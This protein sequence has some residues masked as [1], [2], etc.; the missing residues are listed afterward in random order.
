VFEKPYLQLSGHDPNLGVNCEARKPLKQFL[1]LQPQLLELRRNRPA[2]LGVAAFGERLFGAAVGGPRPAGVGAE[3]SVA[4]VEGAEAPQRGDRAGHHRPQ[5]T[6][7]RGCF[8]GHG[9][10]G[11]GH[12][13]RRAWCRAAVHTGQTRGENRLEPVAQRSA[14]AADDPHERRDR[15][16]TGRPPH[17]PGATGQPRIATVLPATELPRVGRCQRANPQQRTPPRRAT[18]R[19]SSAN[20]SRN[21]GCKISASFVKGST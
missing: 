7:S 3:G 8:R 10:I 19:R 5:A 9:G 4:P 21:R 14:T 15:P 12:R 6:V 1:I 13:R 16:A 17:E 20:R 2:L 11:C 18:G